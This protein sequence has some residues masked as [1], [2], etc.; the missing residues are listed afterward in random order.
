M[1]G[2]K[3]RLMSA[4]AHLAA[5]KQSSDGI[6]LRELA[7]EAGLNHNA[8]YRHFNSLD[9]LMEQLMG[10]F[11]QELRAGIVAARHRAGA[12]S[13]L[14]GEVLP[15]LFDFCLEHRDLFIVAMRERH[16]PDAARRAT[17]ERVLQE[18]EDDMVRDLLQMELLPSVQ[19]RP[20]RVGVRLLLENALSHCVALIEEPSRRE[21]LIK[22][23]QVAFNI[24]IAGLAHH[25]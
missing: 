1:A 22:R 21:A 4:A 25:E 7:R 15:F 17:V 16:G 10:E 24:V 23:G 18:I 19:A 8:F 20:L 5:R 2:G 11:A 13:A 9:Q 12:L 6:S 3:R 14:T